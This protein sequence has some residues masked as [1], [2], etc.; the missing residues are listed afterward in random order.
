MMFF[1]WDLSFEDQIKENWHDFKVD[2][3]VR[4]VGSSKPLKNHIDLI[5]LYNVYVCVCLCLELAGS[6]DVLLM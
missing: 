2:W 6:C 5:G 3:M 4:E 1:M